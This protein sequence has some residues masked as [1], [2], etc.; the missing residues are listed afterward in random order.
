MGSLTFETPGANC[1]DLEISILDIFIT[2]RISLTKHARRVLYILVSRSS[3]LIAETIILTE[4]IEHYLDLWEDGLI[5][6]PSWSWAD[7]DNWVTGQNNVCACIHTNARCSVQSKF[8]VP[9]ESPD[10]LGHF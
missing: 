5:G 2:N 9:L 3:Y 10:D 8:W 4:K 1:L 7:F 6:P